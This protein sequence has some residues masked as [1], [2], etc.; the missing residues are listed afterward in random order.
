VLYQGFTSSKEKNYK[1]IASIF[2]NQGLAW[3]CKIELE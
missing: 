2:A 1:L 3:Q